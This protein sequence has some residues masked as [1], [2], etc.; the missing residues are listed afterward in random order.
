MKKVKWLISLFIALFL[1]ILV[2]LFIETFSTKL[3]QPNLSG[4]F[5]TIAT[6][7]T[8]GPYFL[9][10]NALAKVYEKNLNYTVSVMS[11]DGS[12]D[13]I[14]LLQ[15][16]AVDLSMV[17]SD[18]ASNSYRG[19]KKNISLNNMKALAGLYLN[20]VQLITLNDS[21]IKSV[22]DL[23]GK[24]IGVGAPNSG[25]ESNARTVLASYGITYQ[26]IQPEYLS[27]TEAIEQLK[28]NSIEAAF[29]TSGLPNPAVIELMKVK[30]IR[31]VP[32]QMD[33]FKTDS[34]HYPY[35]IPTVIPIEIYNT[36]NPVPT[37]A[38][39]N[40]LLVRDDL[41]EDEVFYLTKELFENLE[42]LKQAHIAA[43]N[44]NI[45]LA[46]KDLP[47]PL[48]PGALKYYRMNTDVDQ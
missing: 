29:V 22:N 38:I 11:T 41:T 28:N 30:D 39:Q 37:I 43:E 19:N 16:K 48:H 18:L 31:I 7:N 4:K 23:Y 46:W 20:Y 10:G 21:Q 45:N 26:D 44:I 3:K 13:N 15:S 27:Y 17:M 40:I 8:A 36:K 9:I 34:Q 14:Q 5:L 42:V 1:L 24:K 35:F 2:L 25:V 12:V 32:I 47:V 33:D 6:G